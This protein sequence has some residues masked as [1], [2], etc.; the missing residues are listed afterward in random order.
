MFAEI[1]VIVNTHTCIEI[2]KHC[3]DF[4]VYGIITIFMMLMLMPLCQCHILDEHDK[5]LRRK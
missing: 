5:K 1:G 2:E 3:N 4:N